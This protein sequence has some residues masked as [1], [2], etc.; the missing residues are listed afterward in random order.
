L[1]P[2]LG[3]TAALTLARGPESYTAVERDQD[4]AASLRSV[5][6]PHGGVCRQGTA[7]ETGL[8]D[9]S[10]TVVY[11]EAMLTMQTS[12]HKTAIVREAARVLEQG[13]RYG[14]HELCLAP[15]DLDEEVKAQVLA[16]L[17][18]EVHVGVRPLTLAE[19]RALLESEGSLYNGPVRP[20][21]ICLSRA[22]CCSTRA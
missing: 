6:E 11:G 7:E 19:W 15:D 21:C 22:G 20:P 4:A 17:S 5:V 14:I 12:A 8:A 13:G 3:A 16:D 2:G 9:G 1:A 10:A 18:R